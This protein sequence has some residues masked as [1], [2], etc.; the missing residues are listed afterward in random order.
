MNNGK[1]KLFF[2]FFPFPSNVLFEKK[3]YQID[4]IIDCMN[5]GKKKL[6]LRFFHFPSLFS[7]M[8]GGGGFTGD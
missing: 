3:N 8:S 1:K 5:N 7:E 6:F 4:C 2:C